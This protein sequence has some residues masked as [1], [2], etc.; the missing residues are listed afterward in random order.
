MNVACRYAAFISY[1]SADR[2]VAGR[3]HRALER[4]HI[5]AALGPVHLSDDARARNRLYPVFR[6]R[7]ELPSGLLAEA[8]QKALRDSSTLIVVCSPNSARSIWVDK[9]IRYFESIGRRDRIFAVIASGEPNAAPGRED[10]ECFPPA[11]RAALRRANGEPELEVVAGDARKGRD[12]FRNAWLKVVAGIIGVSAGVLSDRDRKQRAR[13]RYRNGAIAAALTVLSLGAAAWGVLENERVQLR[14]HAK[15]LLRSGA[16]AAAVPFAVAG[17]RP[18]GSIVPIAD[19][20]AESVLLSTGLALTRLTDFGSEG[21]ITFVKFAPG[22]R[23]LV[24]SAAQQRSLWDGRTGSKLASLGS[25]NTFGAGEAFASNSLFI[26]VDQPDDSVVVWDASRLTPVF[27]VAENVQEMQLSPD[28]QRL[29]TRSLGEG[30]GELWNAASG[31]RLMQAPDLDH[32]TPG[33]FSPDGTRLATVSRGT[34]VGHLRP[35]ELWDAVAGSKLADLG[36]LDGVWHPKFSSDSAWLVARNEHG[37]GT[38]WNVRIGASVGALAPVDMFGDAEFSPASDRLVVVAAD[39][40]TS[41]WSLSPFAKIAD[42]DGP[43]AAR[44]FDWSPNGARIV[45][46]T[47]DGE[48]VLWDGGTGSRVA[49]L[50]LDGALSSESF[51]DDGARLVVTR[52]AGGG[53]ILDASSGSTAAALDAPS[54][55]IV[56]LH[57]NSLI[58]AGADGAASLIALD[59]GRVLADLGRLDSQDG[60]A[61]VNQGQW[62]LLHGIDGDFSVQSAQNGAFIGL[63]AGAG[64]AR[65]VDVSSDGSRLAVLDTDQRAALFDASQLPSGVPAGSALRAFVCSANAT[66]V[67]AF[68]AEDRSPSSAFGATLIGRP[69]NPCDWGGLLTVRGFVQSLRYWAV[70]AGAPWDY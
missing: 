65:S 29:L 11:L 46:R 15:L 10:D 42:L 22:D 2:A 7:E 70:R 24:S 60:A 8:I 9:E 62:I 66:A 57:A 49:D 27:R 18:R 55:D 33:D 21:A 5:P 59:T 23:L 12:G 54:R 67:G 4:Y 35:G 25:A 17:M 41:L 13:R 1:A 3:L 44:S 14:D 38:L 36:P 31:D 45:T 26:A 40:S 48:A 52:K 47:T 58:V 16:P 61:S 56:L 63:V 43:G 50:A 39:N 64:V 28:G 51:S 68:R 34:E 19:R 6:D 20:D 69:R 30:G 32:I 37:S 53:A